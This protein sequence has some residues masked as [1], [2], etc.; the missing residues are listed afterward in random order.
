M[1]SYTIKIVREINERDIR[2][3]GQT[4]GTIKR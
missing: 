3:N 2:S 1:L 4:V